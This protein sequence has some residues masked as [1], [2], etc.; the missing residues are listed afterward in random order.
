[1]CTA[2]ISLHQPVSRRNIYL[3]NRV[4]ITEASRLPSLAFP[5]FII[6][7]LL[8]HKDPQ[9]SGEEKLLGILLVVFGGVVLP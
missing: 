4:W 1:M 6:L 8:L 3:R 2:D 7:L 5:D 9:F